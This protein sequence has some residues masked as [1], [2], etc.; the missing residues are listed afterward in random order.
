V[1]DGFDKCP[2]TPAGTVVDTAGCPLSLNQQA[3]KRVT[4]NLQEAKIVKEAVDNVEFDF[5]KAVLRSVSFVTL[6]KLAQ[7]L[8]VRGLHLKLSGYT[9]N[10]GAEGLNL[11][12]SK[13]RAEAI[14]NYLI[15]KGAN[16]NL[17]EAVGFGSAHPIADNNTDEG[18][19]ANRRVEFNI[20]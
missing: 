14:R 17:I 18:R 4:L 3:A 8:I 9:D 12:L 11:K 16:G 7:L 1:P 20:Y 5:G 6:N 19:Q 10:R 15:H 2:N 13:E